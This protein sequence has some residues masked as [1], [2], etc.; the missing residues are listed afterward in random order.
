MKDADTSVQWWFAYK[1]PLSREYYYIT[2]D[3]FLEEDTDEDTDED[4]EDKWHNGKDIF[5]NG[6]LFYTYENR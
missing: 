5:K 1:M 4:E 6:P 2:S 3:D